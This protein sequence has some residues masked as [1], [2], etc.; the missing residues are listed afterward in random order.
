MTSAMINKEKAESTAGQSQSEHSND[1]KSRGGKVESDKDKSLDESIDFQEGEPKNS[2]T[3]NRSEGS[4]K[5]TEDFPWGSYSL[6]TAAL[7]SWFFIESL[8]SVYG[9]VVHLTGLF[10]SAWM[11][12]GLFVYGTAMLIGACFL[13][14][15]NPIGVKIAVLGLVLIVPT[16]SA[17]VFFNSSPMLIFEIVSTLVVAVLGVRYLSSE[18]TAPLALQPSDPSLP[19]HIKLLQG[20]LVG[21]GLC[22]LAALILIMWEPYGKV[23]LGVP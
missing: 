20:F 8:R 10:G 4:K 13:L 21:F 6:G 15:G 18:T 19:K 9:G 1:I 17:L 12:A 3:E 11:S 23:P 16:H 7:I 5:Q 14:W 2:E 22:C